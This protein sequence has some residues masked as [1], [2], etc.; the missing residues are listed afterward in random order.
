MS[1]SLEAFMRRDYRVR[2]HFDLHGILV[3]GKIRSFWLENSRK[4]WRGS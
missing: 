2:L 4:L 1:V 3:I